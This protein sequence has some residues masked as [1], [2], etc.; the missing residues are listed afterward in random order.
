MRSS[1][2]VPLAVALSAVAGLVGIVVLAGLPRSGGRDSPPVSNGVPS[3]AAASPSP[4]LR[5]VS[6]R[7][8][9]YDPTRAKAPAG[10]RPQSKLWFTDGAWWGDLVDA[11]SGEAH[12]WRLDWATQAWID[13]GTLIDERPFARADCLWDGNH[14][15]VASAGSKRYA[16]HGARILR[17]SYDPGR[18]RYTLDPD[19]PVTI[20]TSGVDGLVL[21]KDTTGTLWAAYLAEGRLTLQRSMGDDLHWDAPFVPPVPGTAG[22]VGQAGLVAAG[23]SIGLLWS[24]RSE[25][26]LRFA[27]HRDGAPSDTWEE[28]STTVP[29]LA[30]AD[31]DLDLLA[32]ETATGPRL[33]AAART[34]LDRG[35]DPGPLSPEVFLVV[36]EPDGTWQSYLYGRVMDRHARSVL[37]IDEDRDVLY[38]FATAPARGGAIFMKRTSLDRIS[39]ETGRG[40][41]FVTS[42]ADPA[43]DDA[44]STKQALGAATGLVV[45]ANDDGTGR[46]VHG[47]MSLGGPAPGEPPG[48]PGVSASPGTAASPSP[49]VVND[50]IH[51]TFD[52]WA[53]GGQVGAGWAMPSGD[54]AG[55]LTVA[56]LPS[57]ADRSAR[58]LTGGATGDVRACKAFA[59]VAA[60]SVTVEADVL[61]QGLGSADAVVAAVRGSSGDAASLRFGRH[62]TIVYYDGATKVDSGR[63]IRVGSWY[64]LRVDVHLSTKTYDAEVR[65]GSATLFQATGLP[66]RTASLTAVGEICFQT[67]SGTGG[68]GILFDDV[69]VRR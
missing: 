2:L 68:L 64:R 39:F 20:T 47:A 28:S 48:G 60:G 26:V 38:L 65:D 7:D 9:A 34:S 35:P 11:A 41:P 40:T 22:T 21:A 66:F 63:P 30:N 16:S 29:G 14:L 53:V 45:L 24:E 56:A 31:A 5:A 49:A 54:D 18:Q 42:G 57:E 17:F 3:E 33:F 12:V 13:T 44:T 19:F 62:G 6:V 4:V 52:P 46:Y 51:D 23:R 15:Y 27:T 67:S 55:T 59:E 50:L 37:L 36:R 43:I 58:A 8:M 32:I 10:V 61:V 69:L 25:D 1:R